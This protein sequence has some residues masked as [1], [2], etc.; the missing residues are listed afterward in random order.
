MPLIKPDYFKDTTR[1]YKNTSP[2]E[3][4]QAILE[5]EFFDGLL[6]KGVF[7]RPPVDDD[8]YLAQASDNKIIVKAGNR[9][10]DI[11]TITITLEPQ[12]S[13]TLAH[14]HVDDSKGK[15]SPRSVWKWEG[16]INTL[17]YRFAR[18]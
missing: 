17:W 12:G 18:Y 3:A 9:G 14:W 7:A 8:I 11:W 13:S 5:K 6:E 15:P 2:S 10:R 1:T 16:N 4:M